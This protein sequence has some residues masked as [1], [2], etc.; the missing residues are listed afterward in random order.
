MSP[1][2]YLFILKRYNSIVKTQTD[3]FDILEYVLTRLYD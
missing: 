3:A 2:S 1:Q